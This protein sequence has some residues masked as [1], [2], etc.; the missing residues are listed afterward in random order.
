M[1]TPFRHVALITLSLLC[2]FLFSGIVFGWASFESMLLSEGKFYSALCPPNAPVPCE[3]QQLALHRAFTLAST[4]VSVIALPA[5]WYVDSY[6]PVAGSIVAGSLEVLGLIGIAVCERIG[7]VEVDVFLVS[8]IIIAVAGSI[9]M[10]AG[11]SMPFLFPARATLLISATSCLFDASCIVFPALH[12]LYDLGIGFEALIWGYALI[13]AISFSLLVGAWIQCKPDLEASQTAAIA[14][15][16]EVR[17][18]S[19]LATKPLSSQLCS[20]EFACILIFAA[21]QVTRSN[22]YLGT[23]GLVTH[24]VAIDAAAS[25]SDEEGTLGLIGLIVPFGFAVIPLID[26]CVSIIGLVGTLHITTLLGWV[27]NTLQLLP[28]LY[29]QLFAAT[30]FAAFRAF[31]FS[32]VSAYNMATFGPRTMGR[33]MGVCFIAAAFVNL[34]QVPLADMTI[35]IFHGECHPMLIIM[36]VSSFPLPIT[37]MVL[38]GLKRDGSSAT[39]ELPP[40]PPKNSREEPLLPPS[41]RQKSIKRPPLKLGRRPSASSMMAPFGGFV[42]GRAYETGSGLFCVNMGGDGMGESL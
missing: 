23:V 14:D 28:S 41:Q 27:Y 34:V 10:F 35:T 32:I 39:E 17:L 7:S 19:S 3:E 42:A 18:A 25:E 36:L 30:V 31:L 16:E 38:G 11:Y 8:L 15:E 12:A 4:A 26:S 6:G 22:L 20:A 9:T 13:A 33:V 37:W 2:V 5:G 24:S 29:A 1:P 40:L 21:I